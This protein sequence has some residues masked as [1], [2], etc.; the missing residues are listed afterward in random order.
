M[1]QQNAAVLP[2]QSSN[3]V[4]GQQPYLPA[5]RSTKLF[6]AAHLEAASWSRG[7][8]GRNSCVV[9]LAIRSR[10]CPV[11]LLLLGRGNTP[12]TD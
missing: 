12:H 11:K 2:E 6:Y 8:A 5:Q 7:V 3:T 10:W 9:R 1:R 4:T